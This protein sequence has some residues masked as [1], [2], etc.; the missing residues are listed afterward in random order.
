MILETSVRIRAIRRDE[1]PALLDLYRY[2]VPDDLPLPEETILWEHWDRIL[3]DTNLHTLVAE[4]DGQIVSTC[5]LAI[6]LN[7]TRGTR[8]YGLI[9]HVVTHLDYRRRG[10]ATQV[11]RHTLAIAWEQGC[12]KVMLLTSSKSE[13]TYRFYE[14]AGFKRG[15]KTG[16]IATAADFQH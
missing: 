11:L 5:T 13:D 14:N 8:P 16:F 10:I 6:I 12:Y 15:V 9:E 1:L 7:L 4:I 3:A 2:L